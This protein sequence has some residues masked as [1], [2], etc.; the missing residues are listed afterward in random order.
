ME[1]LK[2]IWNYADIH[3]QFPLSKYSFLRDSYNFVSDIMYHICIVG[4]EIITKVFKENWPKI[5]IYK[6]L[7]SA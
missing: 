3:Y 1:I 4:F 2:G 6:C 5:P 7:Q